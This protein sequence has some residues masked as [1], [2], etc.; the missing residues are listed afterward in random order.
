[1]K[2]NNLSGYFLI[3]CLLGIA[4]LIFQLFRPFVGILFLA[5]AIAAITYPLYDMILE[6][7]GGRKTW[8]SLAMCG[9]LLLVVILP[10]F[11]FAY[12]LT[13]KSIDAYQQLRYSFPTSWQT[14]AW[15]E[16]FLSADN[17]IAQYLNPAK[18]RELLITA[19]A[20]VN[21]HIVSATRELLSAGATVAFSVIFFLITLYYLFKDGKKILE[22]LKY[23]SPLPDR[24]DHLLFDKFRQMSLSTLLSTLAVAAA[25]GIVS[26]I[27]FWIAGVPA[28]FLAFL[29]A[30]AGLIPMLGATL[31]WLPTGIILLAMGKFWH[32]IFILL[33]G[34]FCISLV[35]NIIRPFI[36]EGKTKI[37]P[38]LIFMSILG[39]IAYF[40]PLGFLFGPLILAV[41]L[42]FISIYEVEYKDVL[43]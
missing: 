38:L 28:F 37:H 36:I 1:M 17:P 31:V 24:Y 12:M 11:Q 21:T 15:A 41:F 8:A 9:L 16:K 27:G 23:L 42:T 30:F 39:G 32:G 33:Y 6:R 29:T 35:D 4:Y 22:K 43:K 5:S 25:Q 26:F 40:G 13:D 2:I 7:L 34:M 10:S 3:A 19:A 20:T 18:M 14:S